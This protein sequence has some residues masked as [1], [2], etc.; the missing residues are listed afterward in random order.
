[1]TTLEKLNEIK[2]FMS[3]AFCIDGEV[4]LFQYKNVKLDELYIFE[5]KD[6]KRGTFGIAMIPDDDLAKL[7]KNDEVSE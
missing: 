6:K 1:M 5:M 2:A 7:I 4:K 3:E